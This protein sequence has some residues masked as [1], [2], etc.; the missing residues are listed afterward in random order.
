MEHGAPMVEFY[1]LNFNLANVLMITVASVIVFIIAVIIH[2]KACHETNRNA[3]FYGMG[4]G[5]C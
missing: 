4:H 5:F 2:T 3:K 1:G